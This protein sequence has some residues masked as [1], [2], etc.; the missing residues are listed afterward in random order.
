MSH[1]TESE[2]LNTVLQL[3]SE[4]GTAGLAEGIRL[5]V[6]EAMRAGLYT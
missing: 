2:L 6:N 5:L 3:I 4:Q 1:R